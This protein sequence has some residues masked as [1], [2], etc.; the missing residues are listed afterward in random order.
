MFKHLKRIRE[1]IYINRLRRNGTVTLPVNLSI[2]KLCTISSSTREGITIG[3]NFQLSDFA[4]LISWN[5][6]IIIGAYCSINSFSKIVSL[7][8]II[9]GNNVAIASY[10]SI[11]DHDHDIAFLNDPVLFRQKYKTAQIQIGNNVWI[12]DKVTILKGVTIGDNVVVGANSVVTKDVPSNSIAAGMPAK[13][14]RHI[15]V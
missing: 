8:G 3:E 7:D 9:L 11:L 10:V 2:G 12:G 6:R 15:T 13:V 4:Q 5:G 14:L 1:K